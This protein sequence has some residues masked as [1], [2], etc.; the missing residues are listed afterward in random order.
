[1]MYPCSAVCLLRVRARA[2][3]SLC[4]CLRPLLLLLLLL[5]RRRRAVECTL[6]P[7]HR[8]TALECLPFRAA[9]LSSSSAGLISGPRRQHALPVLAGESATMTVPKCIRLCAKAGGCNNSL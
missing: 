6:C 5:L 4:V 8:P 3:V 9:Q 2:Q 1:M 7:L